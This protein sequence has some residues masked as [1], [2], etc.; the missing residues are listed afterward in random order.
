MIIF[1]CCS[2]PTSGAHLCLVKL[3]RA[4]T[5]KSTQIAHSERL[6]LCRRAA[7]PSDALKRIVAACGRR[8]HIVFCELLELPRPRAA[9]ET[10]AMIQGAQHQGPGCVKLLKQRIVLITWMRAYRPQHEDFRKVKKRPKNDKQRTPGW[11]S[12]WDRS[13]PLDS[14]QSVCRRSWPNNPECLITTPSL[15]EVCKLLASSRP[16]GML[17]SAQRCSANARK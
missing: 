16:G 6:P 9:V 1:V 7:R 10:Q 14:S 17:K 13:R 15:T 4:A 5:W 12:G 3:C 2:P 11:P 8:S